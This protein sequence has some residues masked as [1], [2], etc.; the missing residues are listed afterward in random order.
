MQGPSGSGKSTWAE[1]WARRTGAVIVSADHYFETRDGYRYDPKQLGTAHNACFCQFLS[2]VREKM[3]VV[4]DNTNTDAID[5]APY[6][7]VA[8]AYKAECVVV[9]MPVSLADAPV[10]A[11]RNMHGVPEGTIRRQIER[12]ARFDADMRGRIRIVGPEDILD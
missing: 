2:A 4:V 12:T 5:V 3:R 10:L 8:R 11:A 1:A 6:V 7:A 9:R